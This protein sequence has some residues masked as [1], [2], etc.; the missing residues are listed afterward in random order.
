MENNIFHVDLRNGQADMMKSAIAFRNFAKVRNELNVCRYSA[1]MQPVVIKDLYAGW[2]SL[3][4]SLS[5]NNRSS[6]RNGS[7]QNIYMSPIEIYF[8]V[9]S[10][11]FKYMADIFA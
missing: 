3:A 10:K 5:R 9:A 11:M 4:G 1:A 6:N 8:V 7:G 2:K